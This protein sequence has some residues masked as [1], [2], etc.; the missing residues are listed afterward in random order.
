MPAR[1]PFQAPQTR[2]SHTRTGRLRQLPGG[3]LED[4]RGD[5][6]T[7]QT[8]DETTDETKDVADDVTSEEQGWIVDAGE[9][10]L[11]L[12]RGVDALEGADRGA[13]AGEDGAR[14]PSSR[15]PR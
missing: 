1:R 4:V 7:N 2:G 10:Q 9:G 8:K 12:I 3:A 15:R 11:H 6:P 14:L 13:R 5:A